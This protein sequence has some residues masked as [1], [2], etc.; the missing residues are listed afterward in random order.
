MFKIILPYIP[1]PIDRK[2]NPLRVVEVSKSKKIYS[3]ITYSYDDEE[4][5]EEDFE[6]DIVYD[7]QTSVNYYYDDDEEYEDDPGTYSSYDEDS[8]DDFED[9]ATYNNDDDNR[10]QFDTMDAAST[11]WNTYDVDNIIF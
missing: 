11:D 6:D 1:E 5:F 10:E 2:K 8:D 3:S 7:I 4:D 9:T